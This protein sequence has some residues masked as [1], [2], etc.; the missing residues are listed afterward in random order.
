MDVCIVATQ[1]HS[2]AARSNIVYINSG[3]NPPVYVCAISVEINLY[4][5]M[6]NPRTRINHEVSNIR[7]ACLHVEVANML[8]HEI[9]MC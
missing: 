3:S 6:Y 7:E 1:M 8:L 4:T 9:Y 5:G 2:S